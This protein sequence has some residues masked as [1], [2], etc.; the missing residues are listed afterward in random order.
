MPNCRKN[1]LY[2]PSQAKMPCFEQTCCL[3]LTD[4][5]T[6]YTTKKKVL[7][8]GGAGNDLT[9]DI[10]ANDDDKL[11]CVTINTSG[12]DYQVGD[13]IIIDGGNNGSFTVT[14]NNISIINGNTEGNTEI[15]NLD[16]CNNCGNGGGDSDSD[17]DSDSSCYCEDPVRPKKCCKKNPCIDGALPLLT[18]CGLKYKKQLQHGITLVNPCQVVYPNHCVELDDDGN[19][20][21]HNDGNVKNIDNNGN[22]IDTVVAGKVTVPRQSRQ[23]KSYNKKYS[24]NDQ[25]LLLK[26]NAFAKSANTYNCNRWVKERVKNVQTGEYY[27]KTTCNKPTPCPTNNCF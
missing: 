11:T 14:D 17:D 24:F 9:V 26:S 20:V 5:G 16:C 15:I 6:G 18:K 3:E 12:K 23:V 25:L 1:I 8:T 19:I 27:T 10:I 13:T 22:V 4:P 7:T 2:T 21:P